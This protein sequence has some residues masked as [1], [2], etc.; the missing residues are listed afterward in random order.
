MAL[1]DAVVEEILRCADSYEYFVKHYIYIYEGHSGDW[2]KFDLWPKQVELLN[3]IHNN[4]L[5]IT[6]KARQLGV[7]WLGLSYALWLA[8][9]RPS[10]EILLFSRRDD[11]AIAMLDNRF[12]KMYKALPEWLKCDSVLTDN[13]HI[14]ALSNGSTI[15]AF[16]T[17]AGDSYTAT[18]VMVDEADLIENFNQL[19]RAVKPTIDAGAKMFLLSRANKDTP[20]SEFKRI[21]RGSLKGE[22]TWKGIFLPW[23]THPD[24]DHI[25]YAE[26]KK[27][28]LQRTGST[29]DLFEQYP[30]TPDEALLPKS[31]DKRIPGQWLIKNYTELPTIETIGGDV[32]DV[33]IRPIKGKQ[34]VIGADPA[35]GNPTSDDSVAT[36]IDIDTGEEVAVLAGRYQPQIFASYIQIMSE[37]YNLASVLVERNN[38]GH[39]VLLYFTEQ[40]EDLP[41]V[42]GYD[43][44]L[45]WLSNAY[46]KTKMYSMLTDYFRLDAC[47]IHHIRTFEQLSNVDGKTLS[48]PKGEFD[49]YAMS[50][51]LGQMAR[52]LNVQNSGIEV[53][54]GSNGLYGSNK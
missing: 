8:L 50:F 54:M 29:D 9:F 40:C 41:L 52:T 17:S 23:Y 43:G 42:E 39:A 15:R 38:H 45:G 11:E 14:Y 37:L 33:F 22:T 28:I 27:D 53:L 3:L 10:A 36:V 21:F 16:P 25:W 35:E 4:N 24:R 1:T 46:G 51:A 48:A 12:K 19:M 30:A 44:K 20:Q 6:L 7:T 32:F 5:V 2:I 26:Q 34:Y 47:L 31:L 13:N 18:F 49:D